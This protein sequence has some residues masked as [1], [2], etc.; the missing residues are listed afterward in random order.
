MI[1]AGQL[2]EITGCSAELATTYAPFINLYAPAYGIDTKKRLAMWIAQVAHES[3]R[4][5]RTVENLNYSAAGLLAT[6]PSRFNELLA[7]VLARQPEQIANHVYGGRM[8]NTQDGDG[9]KYRGRGLIQLT[10]HDNYA[11]FAKHSGQDV[12]GLPELLECA[13]GAVESA[14]WYWWR[15]DLNRFA[16]TGGIRSCTRVINGG[17]NGI[18]DREA[19]YE[20]AKEVLSWS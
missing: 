7:A 5:K 4:F 19:L 1:S 3:G 2:R 8:G 18:K 14:C 13:E 15:A 6:W 12:I 17:Y 16:D 10:G 9:W 11:A 20:K